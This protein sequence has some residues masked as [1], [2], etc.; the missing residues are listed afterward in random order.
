MT[1]SDKPV[2][3]SYVTIDGLRYMI[4]FDARTD[5]ARFIVAAQLDNG[6]RTLM[7]QGLLDSRAPYGVD[8]FINY[9][10]AP[11]PASLEGELLTAWMRYRLEQRYP[12][13]T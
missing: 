3:T 6:G 9:D 2:S 13:S 12:G 5:A 11:L 10:D 1:T 7:A 8:V 4:S